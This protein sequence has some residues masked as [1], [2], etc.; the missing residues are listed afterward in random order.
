MSTEQKIMEMQDKKYTL[1]QGGGQ[2]R[3]KLQRDKGKLTARERIAKLVDSGSF[4]EIDAFVTHRCSDFGM[5]KEI[6]PS[7]GV[8]TG[9]ATIDNRPIYLYSQDF[10][11]RGGSLGEMHAKKIT[12][13][14]DMAM[15]MGCPIICIND[16]GGARIQE[17]IDSLSGYGEIFFRNTMASGV[18]PQIS[19]ILGPCAGGAVYS[20]ALTDFFFMVDDIS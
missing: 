11:V 8:I 7:D 17:G 3:I 18:I 12:K 2:M 5:D 20:P 16:S 1:Q 13:V 19:V 9:Y 10:T 15:K 4:V 14:M 6:A